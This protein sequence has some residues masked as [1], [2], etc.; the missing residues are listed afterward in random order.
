MPD[1]FGSRAPDAAQRPF[2]DAPQSRGPSS[3]RMH[4]FWIPAQRHT[5]VSAFTRVFDALWRCVAFGTR[6]I[7]IDLLIG[8]YPE[9]NPH[10]SCI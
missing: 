1:D 2:G 8:T 5:A 3:G 10:E 7:P 9:R 6:A 4:G